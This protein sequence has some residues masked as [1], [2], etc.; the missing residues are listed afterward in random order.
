MKIVKIS[1]LSNTNYDP[2][3]RCVEVGLDVLELFPMSRSSFMSIGFFY[4]KEDYY[5]DVDF[6]FK[7][8][9]THLEG[10]IDPMYD[11]KIRVISILRERKI[12]TLL[13]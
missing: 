5:I 3:E 10:A 2:I 6:E 1:R 8:Y 13:N 9:L 4:A 11:T 12:N 7:Q